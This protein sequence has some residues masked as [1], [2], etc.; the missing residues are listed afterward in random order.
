[1]EMM[2]VCG[3]PSLFC[4]NENLNINLLQ[5]ISIPHSQ[6]FFIDQSLM[7]APIALLTVEDGKFKVG[8]QAVTML[9]KIQGVFM[10][11][12][13]VVWCYSRFQTSSTLSNHQLRSI[14]LSLSCF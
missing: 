3:F 9:Q 2:I 11:W 5:I 4:L 13:V 6:R 1:M 12:V 10:W 7:D 8:E 14:L